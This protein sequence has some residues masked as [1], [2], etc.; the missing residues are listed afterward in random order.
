MYTAKLWSEIDE[1][2][3]DRMMVH[4]KSSL[5]A[6]NLSVPRNKEIVNRMKSFYTSRRSSKLIKGDTEKL[7][8]RK[9]AVKA[10]R[11]TYVSKTVCLTIHYRCC[12]NSSLQGRML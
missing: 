1:E 11:K 9:L 4:L 12:I 5:I 6:S 10:S 7:Q 3:K 8:K 2:L